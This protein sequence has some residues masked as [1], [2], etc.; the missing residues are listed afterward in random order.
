[1]YNLLFSILTLSDGIVASLENFMGIGYPI[2]YN[3][4]GVTAMV[5]QILM[6]QMRNKRN[7]VLLS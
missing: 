1:M 4:I 5:L 7:I 6:F 3:T 2:L